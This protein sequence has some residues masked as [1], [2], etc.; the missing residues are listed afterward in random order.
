M[1]ICIVSFYLVLSVMPLVV[2]AA[3]DGVSLRSSSVVDV[4]VIG[5]NLLAMLLLLVGAVA[6][7]FGSTSAS[8][9]RHLSAAATLGDQHRNATLIALANVFALASSF[10]VSPIFTSRHF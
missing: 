5:V 3:D 2:V 8:S 7:V 9:V 4:V 1:R 6:T 10:D